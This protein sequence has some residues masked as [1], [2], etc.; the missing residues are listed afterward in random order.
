MIIATRTLYIRDAS[1]ETPVTVTMTAPFPHPEFEACLCAIRIVWPDYV[2]EMDIA[3]G[4]A[5][6][7]LDHAQKA[8][9]AILYSSSYHQEG[10]LFADYRKGGYGFPV[11]ANIRNVLVG[12]DALYP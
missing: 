11:T 1:G 7:A 12:D 5:F 8:I 3:G 9:G 6:Q 4:D 2:S 10:V